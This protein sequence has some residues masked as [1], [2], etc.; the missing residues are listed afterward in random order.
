M[1][2]PIALRALGRGFLKLSSFV[3]TQLI[4]ANLREE[5]KEHHNLIN[6]SNSPKFLCNMPTGSPW[7]EHLFFYRIRRRFSWPEYRQS[8]S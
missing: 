1:S 3:Q 6:D 8:V 2:R 5:N 4:R 7:L